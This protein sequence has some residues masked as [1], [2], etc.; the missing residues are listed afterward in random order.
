M[1]SYSEL[2]S[3]YAKIKKFDPEADERSDLEQRP[4]EDVTEEHV[5]FE[6]LPRE[7]GGWN[8]NKHPAE[9]ND[10]FFRFDLDSGDDT[11]FPAIADAFLGRG[12]AAQRIMEDMRREKQFTAQP[13]RRFSLGLSGSG[14]LGGSSRSKKF[15]AS[16]LRR[17][18]IGNLGAHFDEDESEDISEKE[19]SELQNTTRVSAPS[20]ANTRAGPSLSTLS[21]RFRQV[22]SSVTGRRGS[23]AGALEPGFEDEFGDLNQTQKKR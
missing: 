10:D 20:G 15:N 4:L 6:P 22:R 18:S 11:E 1:A 21:S 8:S 9:V 7:G 3:S 19:P 5:D 23:E 12:N 17:D 14:L 16:K 13:K 2:P